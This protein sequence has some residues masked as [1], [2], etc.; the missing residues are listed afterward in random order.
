MIRK[1]YHRRTSKDIASNLV[2]SEAGRV[3]GWERHQDVSLHKGHLSYDPGQEKAERIPALIC[4]E[5]NITHVQKAASAPTPLK[6]GATMQHRGHSLPNPS[7]LALSW[8][9]F[10]P[11]WNC[12]PLRAALLHFCTYEHFVWMKVSADWA[13]D[14]FMSPQRVK[15]SSNVSGIQTADLSTC[16]GETES[17]Q[18]EVFGTL[19]HKHSSGFSPFL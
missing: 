2:G 13:R 6:K 16:Q 1:E 3:E 7:F 4:F 14:W 18:V 15:K 8:H 10:P 17:L 11:E 12:N 5:W 19:L 9:L